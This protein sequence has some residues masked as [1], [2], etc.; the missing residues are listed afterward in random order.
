MGMSDKV[1]SIGKNRGLPGDRALMRYAQEGMLRRVKEEFGDAV[2]LKGGLL[3][4]VHEGQDARPT[5]DADVH[6][7][8]RVENAVE[9]VVKAL[10]ADMGDSIRFEVTKILEA[11]HNEEP[12][13]GFEVVAMIDGSRVNTKLDVGFGGRRPAD[14]EVREFP[15]FL[16]GSEPIRIG[17]LPWRVVASEK[18]H[19][20]QKHGAANTRMKDYF[21]IM[22]LIPRLDPQEVAEA[23]VATW[24]DRRT[25]L[26]TGTLPAL[27]D[28][29]AAA[30]QGTWA[31]FARRALLEGKAPADFAEVV[32]AVRPWI[33]E[34]F[35]RA[36][37]IAAAPRM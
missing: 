26:P 16:K 18:I 5:I 2:I 23:I 32:A 17:C 19:A 3:V 9:R 8:E 35:D 37:A 27:T 28:D 25:D 1:K 13:F 34:A 21:D 29:F 4:L 6:F 36:R 14:I 11:E 33:G 12:G 22:R 7:H 20:M 30:M 31:S 10:A 24:E 15:V